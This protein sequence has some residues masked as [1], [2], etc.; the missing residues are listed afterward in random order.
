MSLRVTTCSPVCPHELVQSKHRGARARAGREREAVC[1]RA[2][3]HTWYPRSP[4]AAARE[5]PTAV[6]PRGRRACATVRAAGCSLGG[7][8]SGGGQLASLAPR[9]A[10][11]HVAE[12]ACGG[13]GAHVLGGAALLQPRPGKLRASPGVSA[14]GLWAGTGRGLSAT[15]SSLWRWPRFPRLGKRPRTPG[16]RNRLRHPPAAP[17]P[18]SLTPAALLSDLVSQGRSVTSVHHAAAR[19]LRTQS[20]VSDP[21]ALVC[22]HAL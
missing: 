22:F 16:S 11:V 8:L 18:G 9:P 6:Q 12:Q 5:P 7:G 13:P 20:C 2:R 17:R 3:A 14:Q 15:L 21:A 4:D 19:S 1:A 10:Q